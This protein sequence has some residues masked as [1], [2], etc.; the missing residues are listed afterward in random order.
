MECIFKN[1]FFN[2]DNKI[3]INGNYISISQLNLKEIYNN[4]NKLY[5]LCLKDN[6]EID[7]RIYNEC[8]SIKDLEYF[9][10]NMLIHKCN[11]KLLKNDVHKYQVVL[12]DNYYLNIIKNDNYDEINLLLPLVNLS[13]INYNKYIKQ[14]INETN[15]GDY[16]AIKNINNFYNNK[17]C[18]KFY[19]KNL[20]M[21][22]D[23]TD[24]WI[25]MEKLN[26]TN[27]FI[28]REFKLNLSQKIEDLKIKKLLNDLHSIPKEG[29][30]YL[31]YLYRNDVH[32]DI[33]LIL[34]RKGYNLYYL[35]NNLEYTIEYLNN[36]IDDL[37]DEHEVYNLLISLLISKKYCHLILKNIKIL[38]KFKY[39]IEK[40]K[41]GIKYAM[42]YAWL[43]MYSEECIKKSYINENDRFVFTINEANNLPNFTF[44]LDELRSNPYFSFLVSNDVANL[45]HN[46]M[47]V[48]VEGMNL[49]VCNL[50]E[51]RR[52]CNIF[53]TDDESKNLFDGVDLTNLGITGSIIPACITLFNPLQTK[54]NSLSRYYNEYYC[55]SDIDIICNLDCNIKFIERV[56]NFFNELDSN[57]NNI[58]NDNLSI[59][60]FKNTAIVVND[61]FINEEIVNDDCN[62]DYIIENLD[63]TEIKKLFYK[64]YLNQKILDNE[65]YFTS[66]KWSDNRYNILFKIELLENIKIILVKSNE[67]LENKYN[68]NKKLFI[69]KESLKFKIFGVKLNHNFEIFNTRYPVSFFSVISKFHLPC[70]R[71]YYNGEDVYLLPSCISAA[72][73]LI[74][75]D[76]K[77]F[78]GSVDPI[79]I[80][81]KYRI[82]GYSTILNDCEKIKFIK[83][84]LSLER[85]SL[86]YNN[87]SIKK[88]KEVDG[89]L[90]YFDVNDKFFNQREILYKY[91]LNN[92]PVDLDYNEVSI[93]FQWRE[94]NNQIIKNDS[95]N[96]N[97][98]K[99]LDLNFI[100]INGYIKP[101]RKWY[102]DAIFDNIRD[103][104]N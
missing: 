17:N 88:Q 11:L 19:L 12:V 75:L 23:S 98:L 3:L 27:K 77:Y 73:T 43:C 95:D 56:Y 68:I 25:N 2:N 90:G 97:L 42:C 26:L 82:R 32:M 15:F 86:M 83:Y 63:K 99:L 8:L 45:K 104:K 10:E 61:I 94:E 53:I 84:V 58:Y 64:N 57:Y 16:L 93:N 41:L 38:K 67:E 31:N 81:N 65:K 5:I 21:N 103:K 20:L 100:N 62:Y 74:N 70:V 71:G 40:Y 36:I 89:I 37:D 91:F 34:K 59:S 49:G 30:N 69:F 51:F 54:F 85:T 87:A 22:M 14:F 29:D 52:R 1:P 72:N 24:Y 13:N 76:Y 9:K 48:R 96:N 55:N 102:F 78:A 60:S 79:D 4:F 47:G 101:V 50:E 39:V 18:N 46:I 33:S 80:I 44:R 35:D 66:K 7:D 92:K 6:C 28:E